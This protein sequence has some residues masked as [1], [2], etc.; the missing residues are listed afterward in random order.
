MLNFKCNLLIFPE[1]HNDAGAS[2]L[3]LSSIKQLKEYGF[4]DWLF[5]YEDNNFQNVYKE[6]KYTYNLLET[7]VKSGKT[8]FTTQ[9]YL[10]DYHNTTLQLIDAVKNDPELSYHNIDGHYQQTPEQRD[11]IMSK[12]IQDLCHQGKDKLLLKVGFYHSSTLAKILKPEFNIFTIASFKNPQM[13]EQDLALLQQDDLKFMYG[14]SDIKSIAQNEKKYS[15]IRSFSEKIIQ[16]RDGTSLL[17]LDFHQN[18][19]IDM[20]AMIADA[21]STF[22]I[23]EL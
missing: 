23:Q 6:M 21:C 10:L 17:T 13:Q 7:I 22:N 19:D 16:D 4:N 15:L 14:T 8:V 11:V 5:E 20:R 12:K 9:N 3:L 2:H 1:R 18:P